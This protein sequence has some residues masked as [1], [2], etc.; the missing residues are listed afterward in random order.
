MPLILIPLPQKTRSIPVDHHRNT[1]PEM[2]R[3]LQEHLIPS[4]RAIHQYLHVVVTLLGRIRSILPPPQIHDLR[5]ISPVCAPSATPARQMT[6]QSP[7]PKPDL[8][9][10]E[11]SLRQNH[12]DRVPRINR[13]SRRRIQNDM[14]SR[15]LGRLPRKQ[16]R[17]PHFAPIPRTQ[18]ELA[19]GM[20]MNFRRLRRREKSTEL[21][22]RDHQQNRRRNPPPAVE[23]MKELRHSLLAQRLQSEPV[24]PRD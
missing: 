23:E 14:R 2:N 19:P 4:R 12:Q 20:Q 15:H 6:I 9:L 17:R 7:F 22:P 24:L 13:S 3:R 10:P 21:Q 5:R 16:I 18:R 8:V 11:T 1:C